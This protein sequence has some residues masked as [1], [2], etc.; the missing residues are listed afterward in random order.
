MELY[1]YLS[2]DMIPEAWLI[3]V[4]MTI[5]GSFMNSLYVTQIPDVHYKKRKSFRMIKPRLERTVFYKNMFM[6]NGIYIP[7]LFYW[8]NML[9]YYDKMSLTNA[10]KSKLDNYTKAMQKEILLNRS[11]IMPSNMTSI[12]MHTKTVKTDPSTLPSKSFK[13][14]TSENVCFNGYGMLAHEVKKRSIR[15]KDRQRLYILDAILSTK[16][17]NMFE[18]V[19]ILHK[20]A[21]DK[22]KRRYSYMVINN[23]SYNYSFL[24]EFFVFYYAQDD[25]LVIASNCLLARNMKGEYFVSYATIN[26]SMFYDNKNNKVE[27]FIGGTMNNSKESNYSLDL[28]DGMAKEILQKVLNSFTMQIKDKI[29]IT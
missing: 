24:N 10:F 8:G 23:E 4:I 11:Y 7:D 25:L 21:H 26:H 16:S 2:Y 20:Y 9:S 12:I 14:N 27:Y 28:D 5:Y 3:L 13:F 19:K 22:I 6:S 18:I 29:N 1:E 17:N 15:K